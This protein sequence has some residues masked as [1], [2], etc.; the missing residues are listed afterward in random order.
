MSQHLKKTLLKTA[1]QHATLTYH[2]PF[3]KFTGN[4]VSA[5]IL[6]QLLYW[7]DP[8]E[9]WMPVRDRDWKELLG[10][11]AVSDYRLRTC[12]EELE[13]MGIIE[14]KLAHHD[15]APVHHYALDMDELVS[16][17]KAFT[18]TEAPPLESSDEEES[19]TPP[20]D[21]ESEEEGPEHEE[22]DPPPIEDVED[23]SSGELLDLDPEDV[24]PEVAKEVW[25]RF[26]NSMREDGYQIPRVRKLTDARKGWV[27]GK[28][29][30]LWPDMFELLQRIRNSE[31]L[32]GQNDRGWTVSFNWIW[33][34]ENNYV[35]VLE[36]NYNDSFSP[37]GTE[38]SRSEDESGTE[39]G[40]YASVGY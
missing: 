19:K 30:D 37:N 10:E 16:K 12:R 34:W 2:R 26:A 27:R 11:D 15:G 29:E 39:S 28:R 7:H 35:K 25:N 22:E 8:G 17:W 3:G 38:E 23:A 31:H 4:V 14:T 32:R 18:E 13:E 33:K 6:S 9:E 20:E 5:L 21:Q 24:T 40:S 1:G 36:G